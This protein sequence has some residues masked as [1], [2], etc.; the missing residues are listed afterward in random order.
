[1]QD[2]YSFA[3]PPMDE[4]NLFLFFCQTRP[5]LLASY[6]HSRSRPH[7]SVGTWGV[8][9]KIEAVIN[10]GG[11]RARRRVV[12]EPRYVVG[13]NQTTKWVLE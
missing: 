7:C 6:S 1:M 5:A 10:S 8:K 13:G 12:S 11:G 3:P 9:I 2:R 4:S